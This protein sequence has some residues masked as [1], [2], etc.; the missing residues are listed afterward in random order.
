MLPQVSWLFFQAVRAGLAGKRPYLSH[1]GRASNAG[2]QPTGLSPE[3][4]DENGPATAPPVGHSY[5]GER[6]LARTTRDFAVE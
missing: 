3:S 4:C 5:L 6:T 2:E 1:T